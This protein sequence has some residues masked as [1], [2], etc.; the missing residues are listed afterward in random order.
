M[1]TKEANPLNFS[2]ETI[3]NRTNQTNQLLFNAPP[4][5]PVLNDLGKYCQC[6]EEI[7]NNICSEEQ[8]ISGCYDVS[9]KDEK[10]LIRRLSDLNCDS[11]NKDLETKKYGEVFELNYGTVNSM[12]LGI[13]IIYCIILDAFS[14][15]CFG[16]WS[17]LLSRTNYGN[18]NV[19]VSYFFLFR[20]SNW[21]WRLSFAYHSNGLLLQ[22]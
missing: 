14:K 3:R 9:K 5:D 8:I 16:L 20:F 15:Y 10:A 7:L 17:N 1:D 21:S 22:R 19:I 18:I 12:A 13:L 11:I 6:G 2:D 4:Q